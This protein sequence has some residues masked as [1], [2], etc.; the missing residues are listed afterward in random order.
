MA[1]RKFTSKVAANGQVVVPKELRDLLS[2]KGGD[3][4]V[5]F[6]EE[7]DSGLLKIVIRKPAPSFAKMVGIFSHLK[8]RPLKEILKKIDSE[9]ME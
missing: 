8:G 3:S 6:A 2:L 7:T 5:F 1:I 9:E 4:I